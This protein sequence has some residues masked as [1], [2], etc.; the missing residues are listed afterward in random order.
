MALETFKPVVLNIAVLNEETDFSF[1][2]QSSLSNFDCFEAEFS[3]LSS[4]SIP[5]PF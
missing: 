1:L 4:C 2:Y 5:T 3:A